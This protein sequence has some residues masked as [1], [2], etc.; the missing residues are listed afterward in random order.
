MDILQ[1]IKENLPDGVEITDKTLKTI[2]KEI[3]IEQGKEFI[4]KEQYSKKTEKILELEAN[5][6]ELQGKAT[7]ADTYKKQY[8]DMK[9]KY[10]TD[11]AIKQKELDD[12]KAAS[13]TESILRKKRNLGEKLL[14]E[15]QVRKCDI[16]DFMLDILDYGAMELNDK[17]D[18]IKNKDNYIKPYQEKYA[19]R[20]GITEIKGVQVATP[21]AGTDGEKNPWL[22][23][24]RNLEE[25]IRIYKEDPAKATA[26]AKAAGVNL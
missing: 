19:A 9:S 20:F 21:P 7:D 2:E 3:K 12:L 25:Q 15:K 10:D 16:D 4:P 8:D 17:E 22:K 5:I 13:E 24:N 6:S 14:L 11:I 18:D 26:M 1:I 23:E